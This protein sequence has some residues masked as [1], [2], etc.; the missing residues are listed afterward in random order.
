[1]HLEDLEKHCLEMSD[2]EF[3]D[4]VTN[5]Q[6]VVMDAILDKKL[7]E[8]KIVFSEVEDGLLN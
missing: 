4:F 5:F 7:N 3:T 8:G 6:L 2:E 1:M